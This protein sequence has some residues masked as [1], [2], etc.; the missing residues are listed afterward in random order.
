MTFFASGSHCDTVNPSGVDQKA[1][2]TPKVIQLLK[3]VSPFAYA[4]EALCLGEYPGMKFGRRDWRNLPRMGALS[5]VRNGEQVLEA[6]GLANKNFDDITKSLGKLSLGFLAL[7]WFGMFVQN[8]R[9][10]HRR[11]TKETESRGSMG[12]SLTFGRKTHANRLRV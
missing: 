5:M 4:I 11:Y 7:S 2:P 10:P 8:R 3:R 6:L 9:R 1:A 12:P